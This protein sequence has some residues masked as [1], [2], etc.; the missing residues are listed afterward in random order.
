MDTPAPSA[1]RAFGTVLGVSTVGGLIVG[2]AFGVVMLVL[3]TI[4]DE[5]SGGAFQAV[6][7]AAAVGAVFGMFGGFGAGVVNGVIIAAL[8]ASAVPP[9]RRLRVF[10]SAAPVVTGATVAL[11]S[12]AVLHDASLELT[13]W[14]VVV[15]LPAIL[16]AGAAELALAKVPA[17]RRLVA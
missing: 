11:V 10:K 16:A 13:G 7:S 3:S 8:L 14:L 5:L 15:L 4:G 1:G 2:G 17:L 6:L 9:E 12:A